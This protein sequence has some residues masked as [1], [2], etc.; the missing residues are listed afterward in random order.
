MRSERAYTAET[1]DGDGDIQGISIS[2]L[3]IYMYV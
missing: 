2:G 1:T 3:F